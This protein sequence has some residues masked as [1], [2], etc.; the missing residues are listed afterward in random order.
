MAET[1]QLHLCICWFYPN[2]SSLIILEGELL[3]LF[4]LC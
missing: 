1:Y 3:P 2:A 4:E